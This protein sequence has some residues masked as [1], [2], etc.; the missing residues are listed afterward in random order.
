[1]HTTEPVTSIHPDDLVTAA[2]ATALSLRNLEQAKARGIETDPAVGGAIAE[3]RFDSLDDAIEQ[4]RTAAEFL[5]RMLDEVAAKDVTIT[6]VEAEISYCWLTS[7]AVLDSQLADMFNT[8]AIMPQRVALRKA[9][10]RL[11]A[12][13]GGEDLPTVGGEPSLN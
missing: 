10:A 11:A 1:M 2:M 9:A 6:P 3:S 12:A 4:T 7:I 5:D 8:P 13:M